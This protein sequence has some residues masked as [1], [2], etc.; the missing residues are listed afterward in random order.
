VPGIADGVYAV[1]S[2]PKIAK[3]GSPRLSYEKKSVRSVFRN[4]IFSLVTRIGALTSAPVRVRFLLDI[5]TSMVHKLMGEKFSISETARLLGIHRG[6]IRR[7]INKGL[8]PKPIAEDTAG[9][10]LRYWNRDGFA[11]VKEYR[12]KHFG[13]GQGRRNDIRKK[14]IKTTK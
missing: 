3:G 13:E 8:I 14:R 7:W 5:K 6:T 11:K 9:A 12:D 2:D 10:R 1:A 4:G